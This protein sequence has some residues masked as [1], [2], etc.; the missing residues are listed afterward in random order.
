VLKKSR[1]E[2]GGEAEERE[3]E[4]AESSEG[5]NPEPLDCTATAEKR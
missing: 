3:R 4:R 5:R 2:C 1:G